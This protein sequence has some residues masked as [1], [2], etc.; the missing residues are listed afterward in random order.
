MRR[1]PLHL[2][3][4]AL[5]CWP[6]AASYT[7]RFNPPVG[8]SQDFDVKVDGDADGRGKHVDFEGTIQLAQTVLEVPAD[9]TQ[10]ITVEFVLKGGSIRYNDKDK[11]PRYI[12]KPFTAKRTRLGVIIEV[13]EPLKDEEDTGIDVTAAVLYSTSLLALP[14]KTIRPGKTWDGSH[15]AFDPHGDYVPVTAENTFADMIELDSGTVLRV[16]SKGSFPYRAE[17][18]NHML[19]GDL[20]YFVKMDMDEDTCSVRESDLTLYGELK[21]K[22]FIGIKANINVHKLHVSVKEASHQI[23]DL[24]KRDQGD[25]GGQPADTGA[26]EGAA[27]S[28]G[29]AHSE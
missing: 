26:G 12:G 10:P 4:A 21:T 6:A 28:Q 27:G 13:S 17:I 11:P 24:S 23:V 25:S 14:E 16:D 20:Q 9:E 18:D 3:T 1:L 8:Y 7:L 5:L 22:I 2:V 29:A 19:Y 15:D